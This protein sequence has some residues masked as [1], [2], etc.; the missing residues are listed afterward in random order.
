MDEVIPVSAK[1]GHGVDDVKEWILS[2]LPLGPSYYPKVR[3]MFC[4]C[5][6]VYQ[7]SIFYPLIANVIPSNHMGTVTEYYLN[8]NL[9]QISEVFNLQFLCKTGYNLLYCVLCEATIIWPVCIHYDMHFKP[10]YGVKLIHNPFAF[11]LV[12]IWYT[13]YAMEYSALDMLVCKAND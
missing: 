1:Y 6:L 11:P 7:L 12:V 3:H 2:K 8:H 13:L 10:L 4:S 9:L 5:S